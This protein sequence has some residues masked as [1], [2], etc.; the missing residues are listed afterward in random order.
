M[1]M[2]AKQA[3][4]PQLAEEKMFT[5]NVERSKNEERKYKDNNEP[6]AFSIVENRCVI[7]EKVSEKIHIMTK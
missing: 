6:W 7:R 3:T 5:F 4:S 1:K 2:H